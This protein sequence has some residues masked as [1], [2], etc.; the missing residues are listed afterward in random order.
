MR[1]SP[2]A[3]RAKQSRAMIKSS[4]NKVKATVKKIVKK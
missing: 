3:S 1:K 4:I 2:T